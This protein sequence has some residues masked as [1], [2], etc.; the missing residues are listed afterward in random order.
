MVFVITTP[1]R[2][3]ETYLLL[4]SQWRLCAACSVGCKQNEVYRP[5]SLIYAVRV[6]LEICAFFLEHEICNYM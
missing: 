4:T 5:I 1:C 6:R 2:I 3:A